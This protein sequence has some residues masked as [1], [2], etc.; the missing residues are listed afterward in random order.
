[1]I[2]YKFYTMEHRGGLDAS[3]I[4]RK[5]IDG[6]KFKWYTNN[7]DYEFYC[8]DERINSF[9]FIKRKINDGCDNPTWLL[10]EVL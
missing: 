3:L 6:D 9:R 10:I 2:M 7:Y 4:T 8:Y 5:Q 1:M